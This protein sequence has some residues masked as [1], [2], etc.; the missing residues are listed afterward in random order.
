MTDRDKKI[1]AMLKDENH[2]VL[3]VDGGKDRE[4]K[5]PFTA[6]WLTNYIPG[7]PFDDTELKMRAQCFR[8][9]FDVS[10]RTWQKRG[11]IVH[12]IDLMDKL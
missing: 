5:T 12:V 6:F 4:G 2:V 10:G 11:K 8:T 9:L 7:Q 1:R 3:E